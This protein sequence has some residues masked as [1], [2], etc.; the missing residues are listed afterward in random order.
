MLACRSCRRPL[1]AAEGCA[2]CLSVKANLVTTEEDA[3]EVPS[4]S[5]VANQTVSALRSILT[6]HKGILKDPKALPRH[7]DASEESVIKLGNTMAKILDSSRKL[8]EDGVAA[9]R[10]MSFVERAELFITWYM[11]LPA[12][13]RSQVQAGMDKF[14][15]A[16]NTPRELPDVQH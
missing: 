13:Y 9:I 3:E 16:S 12:T 4:L 6:R 10:N 8:Q 5:D 2:L 1:S 7:K 15:K 14:E 11:S